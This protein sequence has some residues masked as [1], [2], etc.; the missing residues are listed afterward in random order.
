MFTS[1]EKPR[2]ICAIWCIAEVEGDPHWQRAR[3]TF[4][5]LQTADASSHTD[6]WHA[7]MQQSERRHVE[8]RTTMLVNSVTYGTGDWQKVGSRAPVIILENPSETDLHKREVR[9]C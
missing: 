8:A 3:A 7:S 5:G 6:G 2:L 1:R 4:D 9:P